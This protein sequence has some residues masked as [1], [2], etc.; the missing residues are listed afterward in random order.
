MKIYCDATGSHANVYTDAKCKTLDKAKS[1]TMAW[2][3]C[4]SAGAGTYVIVKGA[5]ALKMAVTGA[6]LALVASQ[7]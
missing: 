5:E 1:K 7:F 4:L 6:A 2:G 3:K